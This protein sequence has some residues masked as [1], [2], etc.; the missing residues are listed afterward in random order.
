MHE[1]KQGRNTA[2][3]VYASKFTKRAFTIGR[4]YSR[5]T[6]PLDIGDT[7]TGKQAQWSSILMLMQYFTMAE[8]TLR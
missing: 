5:D 2:L 1:R 7:L 8:D 4:L 6:L 3:Q